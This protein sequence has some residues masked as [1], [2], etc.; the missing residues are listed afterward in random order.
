MNTPALP[1]RWPW[2]TDF[3]TVLDALRALPART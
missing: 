3:L 1:A 2:R